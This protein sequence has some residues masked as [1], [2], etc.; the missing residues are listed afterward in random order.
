M[1]SPYEL[2]LRK[3][4]FWARVDIP[5][6]AGCWEWR[7]PLT[8][9]GYGHARL[10]DSARPHTAHR[11]SYMYTKGEIPE[12]MVILHRCD[13]P[14]CVNPEHLRPGTQKENLEDMTN[15]G[16]RVAKGACGQDNPSAKLTDVETL[17]IFRSAL[18][19]ERRKQLAKNFNVSVAQVNRI[20]QGKHSLTRGLV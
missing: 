6:G 1:E 11:V 4:R 17:D 15:K 8:P 12:G 13:N 14:R 3:A 18:L 20:C 7:G 2:E 16:R 9:G 10:A 5:E 19:G